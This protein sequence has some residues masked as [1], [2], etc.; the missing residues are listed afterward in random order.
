[1]GFFKKIKETIF[2]TEEKTEMTKKME[3]TGVDYSCAMVENQLICN[4]CGQEIDNNPKVLRN[5][6]KM[7]YFHKRCYKSMC[8]GEL[9]KPKLVEEIK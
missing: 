4:G 2:A 3:E 9:P 1:M 5:A 6:G 7:M 8:R